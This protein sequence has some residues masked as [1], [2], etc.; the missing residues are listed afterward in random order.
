MATA[1]KNQK[2]AGE[3]TKGIKVTSRPA[4][5]RRAGF[6]FSAEATVIPLSDLSEEQLAQIESESNLVSQRVDIEAPADTPAAA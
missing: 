6:T 5:F 1:K 3:A 4:T 2:P